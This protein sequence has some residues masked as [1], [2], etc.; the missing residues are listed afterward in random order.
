MFTLILI[1]VFFQIIQYLDPNKPDSQHF[2]VFMW[3]TTFSHL[4]FLDATVG[5]IGAALFWHRFLDSG[6]LCRSNWLDRSFYL[7]VS[8]ADLFGWITLR[9]FVLRGSSIF[10]RVSNTHIMN[11]WLYYGHSITLALLRVIMFLKH[12]CRLKKHKARHI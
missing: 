1:P 5:S 7:F 2:F 6:L 3:D 9:V 4:L 12:L 11:R 10:Y 8:N